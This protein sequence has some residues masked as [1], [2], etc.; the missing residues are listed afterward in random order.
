MLLI[1]GDEAAWDAL[2][3]AE[4]DAVFERHH[5]FADRITELGGTIVGGGELQPTSTATT[6]RGDLVTD[7]PFLETREAFGGFYIIE[8]DDMDQILAIAKHCP[9]SAE[10]GVEIRPIVG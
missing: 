9:A 2:P 5:H 1:Y 7:G 8:A 6:I 10:G 4:K 3:Q